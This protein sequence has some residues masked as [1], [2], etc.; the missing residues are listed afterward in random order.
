MGE[1]HE[2]EFMEKLQHNKGHFSISE[3]NSIFIILA[4][5][6]LTV[7]AYVQSKWLLPGLLITEYV[8]ILLPI[9]IYALVTHKDMK[10]VFKLKKIKFKTVVQIIMI[11]IF[12]IPTIAVANLL[13]LWIIQHFAMPIDNDIPTATTGVEYFVLM[14]VIAVTAG[15]CEETFFRGMVLDAYQTKLG[16]KWGAVFSGLLFGLFHFNPQNLLGPIILGIIFSY[17]VQLTGS[18]YASVIAHTVNNGIAVSLG[19]FSNVMSSDTGQLESLDS[20]YSDP[21]IMVSVII[22]Y[23][24]LALISLVFVYI[25]IQK[26]KKDY[27]RYEA[28]SEISVDNQVYLIESNVE[29]K[30]R[31][32]SQGSQEGVKVTEVEILRKKKIPLRFHLW[33]DEP[34]NMNL[35]DWLPIILTVIGY[36]YI[37]YLAYF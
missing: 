35:F 26:M 30:V 25:T 31:V 6:F 24:L 22:F 2:G 19:Y 1:R 18:I 34:L 10:A 12:L 9:L 29:G 3:S 20:V 5:V 37:I 23:G 21:G 11:A 36:G 33:K 16:Y 8:I 15:I 4:L 13:M 32:R 14:L 27:P 17:L 28:G 7:G